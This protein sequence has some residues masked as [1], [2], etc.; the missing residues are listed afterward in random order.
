[1]KKYLLGFLA[2]ALAVGFS[3]FTKV[4]KHVSN[5][6]TNYYFFDVNSGKGAQSAFTNADV[7]FNQLASTTPSICDASNNDYCLVPFK[8]D[9]VVNIGGDIQLATGSQTPTTE[10]QS[11]YRSNP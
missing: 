11:R 2:I 7:V 6:F 8:S 1:M 4:N 10:I 5:N 3:A 9:Q